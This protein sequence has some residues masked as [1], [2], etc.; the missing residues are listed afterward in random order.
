MLFVIVTTCSSADVS[1]GTFFS[2]WSSRKRKLVASGPFKTFKFIE[3]VG[4]D[5]RI[6][7]RD[8]FFRNL[9]QYC[10][11]IANGF[12]KSFRTRWVFS[13]HVIRTTFSL[14]CNSSRQCVLNFWVIRRQ[15]RFVP[16]LSVSAFR[17]LLLKPPKRFVSPF[18]VFR[19][20]SSSSFCDK[21]VLIRLV[22]GRYIPQTLMS[23]SSS[24]G[25]LMIKHSISLL[26]V[27]QWWLIPS[28]M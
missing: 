9:E 15:E 23:I 25:M 1:L 10:M 6:G 20:L 21:N 12:F 7:K 16:F 2:F 11:M 17:V 28:F 24:Q 26:Y 14:W 4:I 3:I 22:S 5:P 18:K 19:K 8:P 27:V 13:N